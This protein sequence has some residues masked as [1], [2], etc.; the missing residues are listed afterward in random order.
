MA[1]YDG[2]SQRLM[3]QM[4]VRQLVHDGYTHAAEVVSGST[5]T[6][7]ADSSKDPDWLLHAVRAQEET[8]HAAEEESEEQVRRDR[9]R[10]SYAY[11]GPGAQ[12]VERYQTQHA[13]AVRCARFSQDGQYLATGG[14]DGKLLLHSVPAMLGTPTG[15]GK[16]MMSH[17]LARAYD[18]HGPMEGRQMSV[19]DCAFHPTEPGLIFT[20]CRDGGI[21]QFH[22]L[23][24]HQRRAICT[25]H[26]T[27]SVR[28]L[29]PHPLGTHL[30]SGT[31]HSVVR[32]WDLQQQ[33]AFCPNER[34]REVGV[35]SDG[36]PINSCS[37]SG[38]GRTF[39][40]AHADGRVCLWDPSTPNW[41]VAP[42]SF[43]H[44]GA[45]VTSVCF[46][47]DGRVML[48]GGRDGCCRLFELRNFKC[49]SCFG[50]PPKTG[51]VAHRVSATFTAHSEC[52]AAV[53][54][55]RDAV[56]LYD[57]TTGERHMLPHTKGTAVRCLAASPD[58]PF[59]ATGDDGLRVRFW[60]PPDPE[61]AP[62][63]DL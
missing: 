31:D 36:D 5:L 58:S 8:R 30:L 6:A 26:D 17:A 57:R 4:I 14:A 19:N 29:S 52:V 3:Y 50:T 15:A 51:P 44:S 40:T 37:F 20:G 2:E 54:G 24:P 43:A 16:V 9:W 41:Q 25:F 12:L 48:T 27:Y 22:Y 23:R 42:I 32:V 21:R 53:L 47:R 11:F 7:V 28:C 35:V 1:T 56:A 62:M 33:R 60:T 38:D 46:S 18:E 39:A 45:E 63:G 49:L 10:H 59:I 61:S 34:A 55:E 13:G